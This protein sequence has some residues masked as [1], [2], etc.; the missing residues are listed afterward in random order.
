MKNKCSTTAQNHMVNQIFD[1]LNLNSD[2]YI[3]KDEFAHGYLQQE[4]QIKHQIAHLEQDIYASQQIEKKYS[5][6][7]DS[8]K[9]IENN[10]QAN[11]LQIKVQS[12]I[13]ENHYK[14]TPIQEKSR[15]NVIVT[16]KSDDILHSQLE[17]ATKPSL[18]CSYPLWGDSFDLILMGKQLCTIQLEV[19]EN[20]QKV[21]GSTSIVKQL[22]ND[23]ESNE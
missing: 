4:N 18:N 9:K 19:K 5:T 16:L 13:F 22:I 23:F 2:E 14:N 15:T 21:I 3:S 7:L 11:L 17:Y 12:G 6:Q 1:E 10:A 20:N 8:I